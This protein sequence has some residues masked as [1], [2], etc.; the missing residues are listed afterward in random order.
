RL[1][2]G[3]VL[4]QELAQVQAR[5]EEAAARERE[6]R[7]A[8]AAAQAEQARLVRQAEALADP[9]LARCPVCEAELTP[10]HRAELLA[11]NRR[12]VAE[13]ARWIDTLDRI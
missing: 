12:E 7:E 11:R 3:A 13:L 5:R 4:E 6:A 10:E 9:E 2:E 1:A 8:R